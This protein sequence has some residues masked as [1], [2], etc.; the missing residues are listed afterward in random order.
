MQNIFLKEFARSEL[1]I[2]SFRYSFIRRNISEHNFDKPMSFLDRV[3]LQHL[4]D[5]DEDNVDDNKNPASVSA[6]IDGQK[7]NG[8]GNESTSATVQHGSID[9]EQRKTIQD[10]AGIEKGK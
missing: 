2:L 7:P 1:I 8:K 6:K 9:I 10:S 4:K 5:G 3:S